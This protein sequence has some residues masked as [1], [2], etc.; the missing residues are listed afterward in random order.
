MCVCVCVDKRVQLSDQSC[1]VRVLSR[2]GVEVQE[3]T[4][5]YAVWHRC[6]RAMHAVCNTEGATEEGCPVA[7]PAA[8]AAV[9][10]PGAVLEPPRAQVGAQ[11]RLFRSHAL[12]QAGTCEF[13]MLCFA[14][15]PR[16]RVAE[17]RSGCCDGTAPVGGCPKRVLMAAV[18]P[19]VT[20]PTKY[21]GRGA[22][23]VAAGEAWR[24]SR[25][26]LALQPPKRRRVTGGGP[27]GF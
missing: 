20:W 13:C 14:K 12:V 24:D 26:G 25:A 11:L 16:Y 23:I 17:W 2:A 1:P 21:A 8:A 5:V 9:V 4:A 15:A 22:E 18:A 10:A 6:V 19:E 3:G 7:A 27:A